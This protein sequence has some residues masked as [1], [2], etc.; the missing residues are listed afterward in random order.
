MTI[1]DELVKA[2]EEHSQRWIQIENR[3][4]QSLFT[5]VHSFAL[6]CGVPSDAVVYLRWDGKPAI[7]GK[8]TFR[9]AEGG[10]HNLPGAMVFDP[11]DGFWRIGVRVILSRNI[12]PERY[13]FF[14]LAVTERDGKTILLAPPD[15]EEQEIDTKNTQEAERLAESIASSIK[16][17]FRKKP[18]AYR[19]SKSQRRIGFKVDIGVDQSTGR[20]EQS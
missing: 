2:A 10:P 5:I 20:Y 13:S 18:L 17:A 14:V 7:D 15:G 8:R 12:I 1:Y 16:S 4:R 11:E 3:V 19:K 9:A 6:H